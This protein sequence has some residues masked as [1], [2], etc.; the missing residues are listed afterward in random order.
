MGHLSVQA[1]TIRM[2]PVRFTRDGSM[3]LSFA[4]NQF[5]QLI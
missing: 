2:H 4:R 3:H 1:A 5:Y